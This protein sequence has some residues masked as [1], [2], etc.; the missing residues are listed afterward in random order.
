MKV[1]IICLFLGGV[2]VFGIWEI[3]KVL[4]AKL[5]FYLGCFFN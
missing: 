1:M 2:A 3:L 5:N 4:F